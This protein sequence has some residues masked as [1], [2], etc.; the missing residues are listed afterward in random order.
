MGPGRC[1]IGSADVTPAAEVEIDEALVRGLLEDQHPDLADR[2]LE[3]V[4]ERLRQRHLPSRRRPRRAPAATRSRGRPRWPTSSDGCR[5]SG[6]RSRCPCR[7]RVRVGHATEAYPYPWSIVAWL[8]GSIVEHHPLGPSGASELGHALR[9]L[10]GL[11]VPDDAPRSPYRGGPLADRAPA[12]VDRADPARPHRRARR[13]GRLVGR[14][15]RAV[16]RCG[17]TPTCTRGTCSPGTG[18][19]PAS[20][21]GATSAPVTRPTTSMR[22]GCSCPSSTTTRSGP[23][24]GRS[25]THRGAG[26]VLGPLHRRDAHRRRRRGRPRLRGHGPGRVG[27]PAALTLRRSGAC[28]R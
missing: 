20:S 22:P 13:V 26:P 25:T 8:P 24:T 4:V 27:P 10:H 21:T 15:R 17:S 28:A 12:L 3:F 16:A 9:I 18:A 14:P 11:D 19:W 6:P 1:A 23:P 5:R 2:S 7:S